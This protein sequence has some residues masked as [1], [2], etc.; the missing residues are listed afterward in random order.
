MLTNSPLL[1][2]VFTISSKL[3]TPA[4]MLNISFTS[5]Q[6]EIGGTSVTGMSAFAEVFNSVLLLTQQSKTK[7]PDTNVLFCRVLHTVKK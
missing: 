2:T 5:L 3:F 6:A 1:K 4:K 7:I